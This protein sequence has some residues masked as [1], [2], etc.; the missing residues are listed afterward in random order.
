M[1]VKHPVRVGYPAP[2]ME[3]SQKVVDVCL[4]K[5]DNNFLNRR[6]NLLRRQPICSLPWVWGRPTRLVRE[7]L[8]GACS[9]LGGL[10]CA[11]P[12]RCVCLKRP[13]KVTADRSYFVN[14]SEKCSFVGFR[15]LVEAAD[16]S[17]E[18]Q[19]SRTNL[20]L[21]HRRL[22]VEKRFDVSTHNRL[23]RC[24]RAA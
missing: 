11:I 20:F 10:F 6:G 18:L 19:R 15:W 17:H 9:C 13:E 4:M 7:P 2:R 5:R 1:S 12:R 16:L 24:L 22:E 23:P 3:F 14:G 21:R 8:S